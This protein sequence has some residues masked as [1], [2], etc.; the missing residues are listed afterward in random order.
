MLWCHVCQPQRCRG[1][2]PDP[3]GRAVAECRFAN[4]RWFGKRPSA[5]HSPHSA[6]PN[7]PVLQESTR[8]V[9]LHRRSSRQHV[10]RSCF[11]PSSNVNVP[12]PVLAR[13]TRR[14]SLVSTANSHAFQLSRCYCSRRTLVAG[15]SFAIDQPRHDST[16]SCSKSPQSSCTPSGLQ[17][18][19]VPGWFACPGETCMHAARSKRSGDGVQHPGG[20]SFPSQDEKRK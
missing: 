1:W 9:S 12:C 11:R 4:C 13:L 10:A 6:G 14:L 16:R 7:K 15:I 19:P 20:N 17:S 5:S 2:R 18:A 3:A 8:R